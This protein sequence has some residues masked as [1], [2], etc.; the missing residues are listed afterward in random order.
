MNELEIIRKLE[1]NEVQNEDRG[2]SFLTFLESSL[3]EGQIIDGDYVS[4]EEL[5]DVANPNPG[6][7]NPRVNDAI[8]KTLGGGKSKENTERVLN[9]T[10]Y[11]DYATDAERKA[12]MDAFNKGTTPPSAKLTDDDI[13]YIKGLFLDELGGQNVSYLLRKARDQY[14]F[15]NDEEM[16]RAVIKP[17]KPL[18]NEGMMEIRS[19]MTRGTN[20]EDVL[21]TLTEKMSE[22]GLNSIEELLTATK[23]TV[24]ESQG[25][26]K[27][28]WD[29]DILTEMGIRRI[30]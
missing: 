3:Q 17:S 12:R 5:D 4:D 30:W 29:V 23:G 22:Y 2:M 25:K 1:R 26:K 13:M 7:M 14:G 8:A 20:G 19:I 6:F 16:R 21:H 9:R 24:M 27:L 11:G 15:S 10:R 18:T 28:S